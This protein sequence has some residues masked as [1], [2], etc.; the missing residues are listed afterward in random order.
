MNGR[1]TV[2]R[3]VAA[4][5]VAALLAAAAGCGSTELP[6]SRQAAG[7][8][9]PAGVQDPAKVPAA[10]GDDTSCG[11]PLASYRPG[12]LPSPGHM[13]A[14]STMERIR[15][16]GRLVVGVDQNTYLFGF[17]D[18]ATN[19]IQGF[20]VDMLREVS[21]AIF[22]D[23]DRIQYKTI[24]SAQRIPVLQKH[25]V[26]L[27]ADV[28]TINCERWKDVAFSTDYFDAGQRV[29]VLKD[30]TATKLGDLG[31]RKVCAAKGSTSIRAIAADPAKP[32]PVAVDDWTDCLVML[33]QRQ[34]A[35]IS[36]DNAILAGLA[37]QDPNT[38]V[39]GPRFTSEPYG[40]AA[41]SAD[42]DLVRFVNGVLAKIRGDG[43][44]KSIYDRWLTV[45]GPAPSPPAARYR[46]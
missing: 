13:P 38:K 3:I 16:R 32:V 9:R 24:T 44:W 22:G 12:S 37:K 5:G 28:M 31:G 6:T 21:R 30:S 11:D 19:K 18:P 4:L 20:D 34:V 45:L 17:R 36:T 33:Q 15:K 2:R 46:D 42:T 26:D 35:A 7:P 1:V 39:V 40:I 23:P 27:V 10:P 8:P 43:T 14:G 25:D 41:N 29:L